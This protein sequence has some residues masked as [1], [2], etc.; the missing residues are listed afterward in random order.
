M[1]FSD[2]VI[3]QGKRLIGGGAGER[4]KTKSPN[5]QA[6]LTNHKEQHRKR[7]ET[8]EVQTVRGTAGVVTGEM[9]HDDEQK[10]G[11]ATGNMKTTGFQNKTA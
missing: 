9:N 5:Q 6:K 3:F 4:Q 10:G 1:Q 8:H 7:R 2:F 11:K